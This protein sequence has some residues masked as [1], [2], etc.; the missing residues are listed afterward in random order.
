ME[1]DSRSENLTRVLDITRATL[2]AELTRANRWDEKARGQA[3]LASGWLAVT[4]AVTAVALGSNPKN[5]VV[6]LAAIALVAQAVALYVMLTRSAEVW[7]SQNR[8]EFGQETIEAL[9]SQMDQPVADVAESLLEMFGGVLDRAQVANETRG[10]AFD[11][12]ATGWWCVLVIGVVEMVIGLVS[13]I[14]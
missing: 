3:T 8:D 2:D 6:A 7:E 13:R 4:Q 12:A 10:K 5:V 11:R 1:S 9:R 14:S